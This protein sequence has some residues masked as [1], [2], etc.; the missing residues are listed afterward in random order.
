MKHIKQLILFISIIF[1]SQTS[2]AKQDSANLAFAA[3]NKGNCQEALSHA[4]LSGQE[5]IEKIVTTRAIL[6]EKCSAIDFRQALN[7]LGV[8]PNWPQREFIK[9]RLESLVML[10]SDK[11]QVFAWFD[12]NPPKTPQGFKSYVLSA[13]FDNAPDAHEVARKGWTQGSF[14]AQEKTIFLK[15]YGKFLDQNDH[16]ARIDNLLWDGNVAEAANMIDLIDKNASKA[17]LARIAI[18]ERSGELEKIFHALPKK[19]QLSSGVLY[20]YLRYKISQKLPVTKQEI[21]LAL[22]IPGCKI[23]ADKWW[24]NVICYYVR[25][26]I[27]LHRYHD[28]YRLAANHNCKDRTFITEAEFL[29]GW[30]SLRFLHHP[31]AA[32]GHFKAIYANSSRPISLSR[33]AYWTARSY[34]ALHNSKEA[35]DW[36]SKAAKYGHTFYGQMAQIELK[37]SKLAL[38]PKVKLSS[39]DVGLIAAQ[40]ESRIVSLLLKYNQEHL[41]MAYLKSI[42]S[43]SKDPKRIAFIM[44]SL[45]DTASISF[46]VHA[47]R[48]SALYGVFY[49]DYG[50][51]APYNIKDPL[52]ELPLLYSIIRQESSFE[53]EVIDPTD[54]WGLMQLLR[55]TAKKSAQDL[56]IEYNENKLL[57]DIDYNIKLGSKHLADHIAY[58]KGSYLLGIP[59]YN[60]G[61]HRVDKWIARN[62]DPRKMKDLYSVLDWIEKIPFLVTRGYVHRIMEN[63]QIYREILNKDASLHIVQDLMRSNNRKKNVKLANNITSRR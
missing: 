13:S 29:S 8:N 34:K 10:K 46:K 51:P 50:Y 56:G 39:S 18:L 43:T 59:A 40:E 60:A 38:L 33:G 23:R 7:F 62:G 27:D 54:G 20:E 28:A 3:L 49:K 6:D 63:L 37:S 48:E 17:Y 12:Q 4:R 31:K 16:Q 57:K 26:L 32:V 44:D 47:S 45:S 41:A 58:Y 1:I 61:N 5:L 42:F 21:H 53:Q 9:K 30:L 2:V 25:E 35:Q 52:I 11:R 36:F 22:Q 55:P 14:D 19:D 15:K 24:N